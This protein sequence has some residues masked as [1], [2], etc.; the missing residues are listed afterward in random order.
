LPALSPLCADWWLR[1][2]TARDA[3]VAV[4][5][6]AIAL[7]YTLPVERLARLMA[8]NGPVESTTVAFYLVAALLLAVLRPA[9]VSRRTVFMLTV[10]LAAF[11][12][13]EL[14]LHKTLT[15]TSMLRVSF[16][17]GDAPLLQKTISLLLLAPVV[18]ALVG[19]ARRTPRLLRR[20]QR[21][22]AAAMTL[23]VFAVTLLVS[24]VADRLVNILLSDLSIPV[25]P[26]LSAVVLSLEE[27][28]ELS[29]PLLACLAWAQAF[30]AGTE[31]PAAGSTGLHAAP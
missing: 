30:R 14:D 24:K 21:G 26:R 19:L 10:L 25:S 6:I 17:G 7:G 23:A 28:L 20:V 2:Q 13:R 9:A 3:A 8:E 31:R 18:V 15:G 16:Y 22:D 4:A 5:V 12:A 11:G 1:P 29:L 27:I